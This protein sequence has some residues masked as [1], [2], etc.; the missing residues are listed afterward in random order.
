V[1]LA[2]QASME[3]DLITADIVEIS[4]FPHLAQKYQVRGVPKTVINEDYVLEGAAPEAMLMDKIGEA[5]KKS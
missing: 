3:N 5:V 1:R 4:E 2:Q